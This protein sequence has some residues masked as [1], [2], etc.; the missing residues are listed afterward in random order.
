MFWKMGIKYPCSDM[1]CI[2][3]NVGYCGKTSTVQDWQ[4][5]QNVFAEKAWGFPYHTIETWDFRGIVDT[6]SERLLLREFFLI[7]T[8]ATEFQS[9]GFVRP[10]IGAKQ[11]VQCGA[12]KRYACWFI[13][14]CKYSHKYH[15]PTS[16]CSYVHQLSYRTGAPHFTYYSYARELPSGI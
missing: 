14:P 11:H 1:M 12:P 13:T 5:I 15:K 16:Y 8:L 7:A 2:F 10:P 6:E 3:I 4:D 9:W